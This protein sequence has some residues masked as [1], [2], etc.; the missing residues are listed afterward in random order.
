MGLV[1]DTSALIAVVMILFQ[2]LYFSAG[3]FTQRLH[4]LLLFVRKTEFLD[5]LLLALFHIGPDFRRTI[6]VRLSIYNSSGK[7]H[8]DHAYID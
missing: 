3:S 4:L 6:A 7:K 8:S 5:E 1:I 2:F